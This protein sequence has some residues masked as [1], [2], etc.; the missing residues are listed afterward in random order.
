MTLKP[1]RHDFA[2]PVIA[3]MR[4][5]I[6][7]LLLAAVAEA[8]LS[9]IGSHWWNSGWFRAVIPLLIAA[10]AALT[11][12]SSE[13]SHLW[14][15]STLERTADLDRESRRER[16]RNHILEMLVSNEPLGTVFD[17]LIHSIR[18]TV[19]RCAL[20]NT[21]ETRRWVPCGGSYRC[22]RGMAC[23][24]AGSTCGAI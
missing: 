14:R 12:R 16:E 3:V 20:R 15:K 22:P 9:S 5:T 17:A 19:P 21:S 4:L 6:V 7:M 8:Q 2:V 1:S 13:R 18:I 11:W 23:R 10:T 24:P